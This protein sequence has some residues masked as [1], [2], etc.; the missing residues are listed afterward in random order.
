MVVLQVHMP[1]LSFQLPLC[2]L[3]GGSWETPLILHGVKLPL[4]SVCQAVLREN[5]ELFLIDGSGPFL[6]PLPCVLLAHLL[7]KE[8]LGAQARQ[9][10]FGRWTLD[11][12]CSYPGVGWSSPPVTVDELRLDGKEVVPADEAHAMLVLQLHDFAVWPH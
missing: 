2:L 9:R 6:D 3:R 8:N 1:G 5:V 10:R 11:A 7:L 4:S 12:P